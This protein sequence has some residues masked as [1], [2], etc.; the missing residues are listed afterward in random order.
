MPALIHKHKRRKI[1]KN[2][3][4]YPHPDKWKNLV[5]RLIYPMALFGIAFTIP[6]VFNIW[7]EKNAEGVSIYSWSA[8]LIISGFMFFYGVLHKEKPLMI[9]YLMWIIVHLMV[10]LGLLM[11][12]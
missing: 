11:Y 5:D 8:F 4:P 6:Q 10:V 7:I 2:L 9:V 3:E 1:F 12:G